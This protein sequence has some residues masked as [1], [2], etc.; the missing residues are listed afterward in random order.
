MTTLARAGMVLTLAT[1]LG[2]C[3]TAPPAASPAPA[4]LRTEAVAAQHASVPKAALIALGIAAAA[5]VIIVIAN[6]GG[7]SAY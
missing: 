6:S 2:G 1:A 3:A 7:A 4:A 5:V